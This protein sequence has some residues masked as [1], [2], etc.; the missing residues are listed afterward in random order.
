MSWYPSVGDLYSTSGDLLKWERALF[1]GKVLSPASLKEMTTPFRGGYALGLNNAPLI[2]GHKTIWHSGQVPG[3]ESSMMYFPDEKDGAIVSIVLSNIDDLVMGELAD[4]LAKAV[5]GKAVHLAPPL[6]AHP[7]V[8]VSE[9]ILADYV[10]VYL[11]RPGEFRI[12]IALQE[13]HLVAQA[14]GKADLI[15]YPESRTRFFINE[16]SSEFEFHRSPLSGA[17][18][19]MTIY[20]DGATTEAKR[21]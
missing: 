20:R 19:S 6:M 2:P 10:G 16:N 15:L 5:L 21:N 9:Q 3:F 13:G 7:V 18:T 1:G 4:E 11:I 14:P 8:T 17:A 12:T